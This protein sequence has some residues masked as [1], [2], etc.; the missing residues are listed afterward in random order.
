[1]IDEST[2]DPIYSNSNNEHGWLDKN[3]WE[4]RKTYV[5]TQDD[6]IYEAYLKITKAQDGRNILYGVNLDIN[7][8]IAVDKGATQNRAAVLAAM[9][10]SE[11]VAQEDPNVLV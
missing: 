4:S 7:K 5:L 1:M 10:S 9:P 11:N 2:Y 3:G 8:G 6:N